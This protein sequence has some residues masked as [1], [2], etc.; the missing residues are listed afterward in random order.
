MFLFSLVGHIIG[1]ALRLLFLPL[2]LLGIPIAVLL[3]PLK[4]IVKLLTRHTMLVMVLFVALLVYLHFRNNNETLPQ[5]APVPA[6]PQQQAAV[7]RDRNGLPIV[8]AVTVKEDGDSNFA[9]DIYALMNEQERAAY[10]QH[11]YWAM[12]SLP[13]GQVHT[14]NY[15]NIAGTLR[16]NDT[17]Q[18][19]SGVTC[20]RFNEVLKVHHIQQT[21][22]G[23]ACQ[24]GGGS[25]CKLRPN[26]TP[27]CGL[28]GSSGG[29][30]D[31]LTNSIRG[32][33]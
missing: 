17:F 7:P 6:Q 15:Y 31:G 33:F 18:N 26:A 9:T 27:A 11:Y 20:R 14:W 29:V 23:T 30:L 2:R 25:W 28:S 12:A 4:I 32:L 13:N 16:A 8:Q 3:L 24:Q 1:L 21:I 19:N 22:S 10:S 5:L